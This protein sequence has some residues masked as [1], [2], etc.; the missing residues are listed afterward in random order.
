MRR[1]GSARGGMDGSA[2]IRTGWL[3]VAG[4]RA[5]YA[6]AGEGPPVVV[7]AGLGLSTRFYGPTLE[8]CA[9][10]GLRLIVPD[11]PGWGVTPG[12]ATGCSVDETAEWLVEFSDALALGRPGWIGHSVGCQVALARAARHPARAAA[13]ALSGPTGGPVRHRLLQQAGKLVSAAALEPP[14]LLLAVV[15]DYLRV[16]PLAYVGSWVRAARDQPLERLDR[17]RCPVLV[18][19]GE[20]DPMPP[21]P[22]LEALRRALPGTTVAHLRGGGHGLPR[23][24]A[25]PFAAV[26]APFFRGA[27]AAYQPEG[28]VA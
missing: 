5:H 20:R 26:A 18:L 6:E 16:S 23:E 3:R 22:F 9:R 8:A 4:G 14:S 11:L 28:D 13:L 15:R 1:A 24:A 7:A 27:L 10:A 21:R 17:V 19:V 2:R 12:P 25:E